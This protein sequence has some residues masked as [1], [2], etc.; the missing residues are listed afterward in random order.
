MLKAEGSILRPPQAIYNHGY[1]I[2]IHHLEIDT[3]VHPKLFFVHP[4][5]IEHPVFNWWPREIPLRAAGL[6]LTS[7]SFI[8]VLRA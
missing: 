7:F 2:Y 8:P 4:T 5:Y 3:H 1:V 6:L